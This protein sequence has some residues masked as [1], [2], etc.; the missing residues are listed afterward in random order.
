MK[1]DSHHDRDINAQHSQRDKQQQVAV[2]AMSK[3]ARTHGR[4]SMAWHAHHKSGIVMA[5]FTTCQEPGQQHLDLEQQ[6]A[7][8]ATT[9]QHS[10]HNRRLFAS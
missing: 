8:T 1:H 6:Q 2:A 3:R 7:G 5:K 9:K 10:C 4:E